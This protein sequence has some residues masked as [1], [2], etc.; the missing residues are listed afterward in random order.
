[1]IDL[2]RTDISQDI[3]D[4]IELIT[5]TLSNEFIEKWKFKYSE[6]FVKAF[7]EKLLDSFKKSKVL[8]KSSLENYLKSKYSYSDEQIQ[9]FF[10]SIDIELYSPVISY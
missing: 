8:K 3:L 1:M 9:D 7:Q 4:T 10:K 6:R 5:F 2:S